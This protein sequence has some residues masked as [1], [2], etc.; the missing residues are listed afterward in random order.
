MPGRAA[1]PGAMS[2]KSDKSC[3]GR[4]TRTEEHGKKVGLPSWLQAP[5][6]GQASNVP[7]AKIAQKAEQFVAA[8]LDKSKAWT[9][10][11]YRLFPV[12]EKLRHLDHISRVVFPLAYLI[13]VA[14]HFAEI[15]YGRP[16]YD[17]LLP[18][19]CYKQHLQHNG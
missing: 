7:S 3:S 8:E 9:F 12:L 4:Q 15:D 11:V 10:K 16:T 17:R 1:R 14:C 6:A 2:G 13:Y 18:F 5:A 19:E